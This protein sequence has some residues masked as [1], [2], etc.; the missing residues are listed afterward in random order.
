[1]DGLIEEDLTKAIIGVAIEV[2]KYWG[3]GLV[4]S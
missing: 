3:S 4:E 1:M 2:H